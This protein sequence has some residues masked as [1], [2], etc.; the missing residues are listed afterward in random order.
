MGVNNLPRIN[1]WLLI[2][3]YTVEYCISNYMQWIMKNIPSMEIY[4]G[5]KGIISL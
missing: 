4:N 2:W 1:E 3:A 5:S